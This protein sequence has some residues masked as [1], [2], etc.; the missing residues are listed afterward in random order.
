VY[1]TEH[2]VNGTIFEDF[3]RTS[4]IPILKP[5]NETNSH[6]VIILDNASVHHLD[7]ILIMIY[8]TGAI[9]RF[10]PVYSPDLNPAFF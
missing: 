5:F 6:S 10:L 3:V 8:S 1:L 4:L 7:S 2:T 9:V